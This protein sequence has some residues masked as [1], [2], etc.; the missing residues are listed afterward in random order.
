[1]AFLSSAKFIRNQKAVKI[2]ENKIFN[3]GFENWG[4]NNSAS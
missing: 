4:K 3:Q 1:M 2:G